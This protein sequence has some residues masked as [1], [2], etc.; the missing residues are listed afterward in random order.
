MKRYAAL[1]RGVSPM[2]ARMQELA[3]AFEAAGFEDVRTVLASGNV[4]FSTAAASPATLER[5]AEAAME[6][7]LGRTF[8]TIVRPVDGLRSMLEADAYAG[9]RLIA[10]TKRVVTFLRRK[11]KQS[12]ELPV[13][14]DGARILLVKGTEVFSAYVPSPRGPVFM[15]LIEKT[16]GKDVTTRTWE[17]IGKIAK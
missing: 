12:L 15:T 13:E 17:T 5:R 14:L 16:F 1:L 7:H 8:L 6:K 4:L 10:G 11:P 9:F 3:A 2:N